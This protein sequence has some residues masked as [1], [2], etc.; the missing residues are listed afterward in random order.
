MRKLL[1]LALVAS[2]ALA[3][4]PKADRESE[5]KKTIAG[6]FV[7]LAT[8]CQSKKLNAEGRGHVAEALALEPDNAKAKALKLDGDSAASDADKAEYA[9]KLA[10]Y[11]KALA[12]LYRELSTQKHQNKDDARF[13][14][15]LVR[16]YELDQKA[17]GP[18]IDAEWQAAYQKRDWERAQRLISGAEAIQTSPAR[19][20]IAHEVELRCAETAPILKTASTHKMQYYLQLPKGWTPTKKYTIV[21]GV[22][23]AGCNFKGMLSALTQNRGDLPVICITPQTFS[24][25]NSLAGAAG[26]YTY[27]PDLVAE[28]D[29]GDRFKFDEEGLLAVIADVKKDF[30]GEDKFCITGFSGG[31][32]LTWLFVFQH[33]DMLLG[34]SPACANFGTRKYNIPDVP[35][36][37]TVPVHAYQ[38]D[39]DGYWH[40]PPNLEQQ[41]IDAKKLADENGYK[42]VTRDMVPGVGHSGCSDKVMAFFATLI[43][44]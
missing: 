17:I 22:E 29:A 24:N 25:T 30:S 23:G 41:W 32:N 13:D 10:T 2:V 33:P 12:P 36:K 27:P 5:L 1:L 39:K 4:P 34:A 8:W 28:Y 20:K 19:A 7:E 40:D 31:G 42:N 43:K 44:K 9:K 15:Y 3:G 18:M 35:E 38:G 16:A 14:G 37:A 26:K 6:G 21:V 11:G